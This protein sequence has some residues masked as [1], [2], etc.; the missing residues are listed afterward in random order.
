MKCLTYANRR[1]GW[2][3][4]V[5]CSRP[6]RTEQAFLLRGWEPLNATGIGDDGA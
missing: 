1:Y 6:R 3:V 5:R 4:T 2:L